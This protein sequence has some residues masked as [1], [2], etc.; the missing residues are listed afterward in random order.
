MTKL[1]MSCLLSRSGMS[2]PPDSA[3]AVKRRMVRFE[4]HMSERLFRGASCPKPAQKELSFR[5][6]AS[7]AVR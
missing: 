7:A 5:L 2:G 6:H 3:V 4:L 1:P